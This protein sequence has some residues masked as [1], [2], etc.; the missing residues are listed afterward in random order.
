MRDGQVQWRG[1]KE[2]TLPSWKIC[3]T[4][5]AEGYSQL[6]DDFQISALLGYDELVEDHRHYLGIL[7]RDSEEFVKFFRRRIFTISGSALCRALGTKLFH[8]L[9]H[10]E[11]PRPA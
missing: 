7:E 11:V 1:K 8:A 4:L 5:G 10:M 2:S 6:H 9:R 3:L